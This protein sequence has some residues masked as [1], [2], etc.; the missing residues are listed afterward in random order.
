MRIFGYRKKT[1]YKNTEIFKYRIHEIAEIALRESKLELEKSLYDVLNKLIYLLDCMSFP[2]ES[3]SKVQKAI[4]DYIFHLI[5]EL[6]A[7]VI[8]N[9]E[10]LALDLVSLMSDVI[11]D[12][13]RT[14]ELSHSAEQNFHKEEKRA[15]YHEEIESITEQN[16]ELIRKKH[17][18]LKEA[19]QANL[20]NDRAKIE[21]IE[22]EYRMLQ[23]E[24]KHLDE[25]LKQLIESYNDL[26]EN[27]NR[28]I[29]DKKKDDIINEINKKTNSGYMGV[30]EEFH[31]EGVIRLRNPKGA[32][33]LIEEHLKYLSD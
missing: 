11:S 33:D 4:D 25:T 13:R 31:E 7:A 19:R 2:K 1:F 28:T 30:I 20:A 9:K 22:V 14:G 18:I 23:A 12:C 17:E 29:F 5:D 26:G 21:K 16:E 27:F 3:N 8:G 24:E 32:E 6:Q 15:Q 10:F